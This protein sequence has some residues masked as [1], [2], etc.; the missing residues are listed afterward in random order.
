[1]PS[2]AT[3]R[4]APRH[5]PSI[6]R[7]PWRSPGIRPASFLAHP[8]HLRDGPLMAS[9]FATSCWLARAA[10]P[11]MRF[12]SLGSRFRLRL[13]SHPASRRRSLPS[14]CGWCH[15]P[16]RGTC[17]PERLVMPGVHEGRRALRPAVPSSLVFLSSLQ[18]EPHPPLIVL[19]VAV[20]WVG[21]DLGLNI[22]TS[23]CMTADGSISHC[24]RTCSRL[25]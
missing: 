18:A 5:R 16:P 25:R 20:F 7:H 1:M 4:S 22:V 21:Q 24:L 3:R 19:S 10:P 9:G 8:P 12:V 17:T 15:Q 23:R 14:T 6:L 2:H 11:L 13:P